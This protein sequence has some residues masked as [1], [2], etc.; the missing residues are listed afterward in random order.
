MR[1][2]LD[3]SPN[4]SKKSRLKSDIKFVIIHYTGMQSEI[5]KN[6]DKEKI[7]L[8]FKNLHKIGYRYFNLNKRGNKDAFIIKAFQRR[9]LPNRIS[10]KIDEI[11]LKIS[12]IL[13]KN[14]I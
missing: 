14:T 7:R 5:D 2:T 1:K 10:G 4:Y 3:L 12:L 9:Y 6:N 11:T 8:F 13:A